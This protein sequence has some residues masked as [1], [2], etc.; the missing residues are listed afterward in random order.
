[1]C[2]N[3]VAACGEHIT[4]DVFGRVRT[5]SRG[6]LVDMAHGALSAPGD[7]HGWAPDVVV[8]CQL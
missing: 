1:M 2:C 5:Q 3:S 8:I 7:K 6:D 4:A